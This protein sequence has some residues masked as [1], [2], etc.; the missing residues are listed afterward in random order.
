M[1]YNLPAKKKIMRSIVDILLLN[2]FALEFD[3]S[4]RRGTKILTDGTIEEK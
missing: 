3:R 4:L 1:L 2:A